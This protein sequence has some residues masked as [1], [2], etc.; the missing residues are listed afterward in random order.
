MSVTDFINHA[1][2]GTGEVM[3]IFGAAE[4]LTDDVATALYALKPISGIA[5][6]TFLMALRQSNFIEHRNREWC[7]PEAVRQELRGLMVAPRATIKKAHMR[8][9]DIAR[10]AELNSIEC[11]SPKYLTTDAGK[12]YHAAYAGKID[13]ALTFYTQAASGW[14]RFSGIHWLAAQF[15]LEQQEASVLP[16]DS[17]NLLFLR[18][19]S[20]FKENFKHQA[21]RLFEK[22]I[23]K[24]DA[25]KFT[26]IACDIVGN[27]LRGK[28]HIRAE[29]LFR[30]A[31]EISQEIGDCAGEGVH[32][33]NLA[34]VLDKKN[35]E[36]E[37]TFRQSVDI[38][39]QEGDFYSAAIRKN[40]LADHLA[41]AHKSKH[42]EAER[43]LREAIGFFEATGNEEKAAPPLT[44]LARLIAMDK[45]QL[46]KAEEMYRTAIR[47]AE[48][49]ED[50]NSLSVRL[51]GLATL[52]SKIPG[53]LDEAK[54]LLEDN[55][56]AA[57]KDGDQK[58]IKKISRELSKLQ[59]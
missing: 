56:K 46:E 59:A 12:A 49:Y 14:E 32:L 57:M 54:K 43:L 38:A 37:L 36:T 55:L 9:L 13:Q 44:T 53:R 33:H 41:H 11:K 2:S 34:I 27:S 18:G 26:A 48:K 58:S 22:I 19:I 24:D 35:S 30:R 39:E 6:G 52:L 20:L 47:I 1:P 42:P 40:S 17:A 50:R 4:S 25:T 21:S 29:K 15:A 28:N 8:L 7:F 5:A 10:N 16:A 45:E 31:I 23:A 51:T 3:Q